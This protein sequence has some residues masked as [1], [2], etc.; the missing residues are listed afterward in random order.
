MESLAEYWGRF[1]QLV[2]SCPQ[3]QISEQLL[4]QYFYEGLLPMD[5]NILDAASETIIDEL[6][7]LVRKLAVR[8][9]QSEISCGICIS[10]EH[11]IDAC[12]TLK[13]G[14]NSDLPQ[15][16]ATNIYNP[17]SNNQYSIQNLQTQVRQ[18]VTSMNAMQQTQGSNQLP[19]QIIVNPKVPNVSEISSRSGK[20]FEPAPTPHKKNKVAE[21]I[22]KPDS[23]VVVEDEKEKEYAPPIPFPQRTKKNK[24]LDEEDK[25]K[26]ILDIFRK[27][28]LNIPLLNVI[29]KIL[30]YVK[31]LKDLSTHKRRLKGMRE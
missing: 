9:T 6:T 17:Q 7:S 29:K 13:E 28:A 12:P 31:F 22:P 11:P 20:S 23:D 16:Y 10:P 21:P 15:A 3:N 18:L 25:D 14:V 4:I 30:K 26:E 1:K 19:T 2:S 5:K 24:K 27:V 8:K